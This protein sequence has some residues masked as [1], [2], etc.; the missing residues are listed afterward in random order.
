MNI[1]I[2]DAHESHTVAKTS[3][4]M[5]LLDAMRNMDTSGDG[6]ID[7]GEFLEFMTRIKEKKESDNAWSWLRSVGLGVFVPEPTVPEKLA[8][9]YFKVARFEAAVAP[10]YTKKWCEMQPNGYLVMAER[11]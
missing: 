1:R 2:N 6:A 8:P 7:F 5:L 4:S 3:L 11:K 9:G 10:Q